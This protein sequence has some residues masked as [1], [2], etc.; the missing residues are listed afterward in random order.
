[1]EIATS[2][3]FALELAKPARLPA[4]GY[5]VDPSFHQLVWSDLHARLFGCQSEN[6]RLTYGVWGNLFESEGRTNDQLTRAIIRVA[7][8][9]EIPAFASNHLQAIREELANLDTAARAE[10]KR[11]ESSALRPVCETCR[12]IGWVLGLPE[13]ADVEDGRWVAKNGVHYETSVVCQCSTGQRIGSAI[14]TLWDA[15]PGKKGKWP[16]SIHEYLK[17]NP[18]YPTQSQAHEELKTAKAFTERQS[19]KTTPI[20]KADPGE[21]RKILDAAISGIGQGGR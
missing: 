8:R 21:F 11:T 2:Q 4:Q 20:K 16:L 9:P 17:R 10:V 1:M 13:L 7:Q 3:A 14:K 19:E 12:G 15:E 5:Y 6:W 18:E